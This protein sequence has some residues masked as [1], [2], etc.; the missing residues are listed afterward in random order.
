MK[1][2]ALIKA[3]KRSISEV[4]EKMF[5]LPVDFAE[6]TRKEELWK[7]EGSRILVTRLNFKG[8]FSGYFHFFIPEDLMRSLAASFLGEDEGSVSK[9]HVTETVKEIA[10]M[11]AGNTFSLFDDQKIFDLGIPEM[12]DFG[13]VA[14]GHLG[15][16]D[17]IF[18]AINTV[19][20]CLAVQ[21]GG[22][23]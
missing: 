14:K 17:E 7:S 19:D 15:P 1:R 4:L 10:N 2:E 13:A 20:N 5:F 23:S 8:P 12:V 9:A 21:L 3:M 22:I 11:I 16:E 18:I 6:A